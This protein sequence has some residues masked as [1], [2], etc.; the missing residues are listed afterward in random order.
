M[1]FNGVLR[2]MEPKEVLVEFSGSGTIA[3][4]VDYDSKSKGDNWMVFKSLL[5]ISRMER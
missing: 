3:E 1:E 4:F 5:R 2:S